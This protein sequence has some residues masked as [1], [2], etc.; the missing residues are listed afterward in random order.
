MNKMISGRASNGRMI[1]G[2]VAAV[3]ALASFDVSAAAKDGGTVIRSRALRYEADSLTNPAATQKLYHRIRMTARM[4]CHL[5]SDN[6]SNG[7]ALA[8]CMR[9]AT[10]DAVASVNSV[11]LTALHRAGSPAKTVSRSALG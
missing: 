10:S 5:E 1:A 8:A 3:L 9:Q 2:L 7:R 4:V 11:E 6:V